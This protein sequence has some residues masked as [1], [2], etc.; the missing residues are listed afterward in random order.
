MPYSFAIKA[1]PTDLDM[2]IQQ[3]LDNLTKPPGS[4]GQLET[5]AA[6]IARIQHTL[7]PRLSTLQHWVFAADHGV[8]AQG[9]SPYPRSVTRQM[10]QNFLA[11]GAAINQFCNQHQ[12]PL[13]IV[14]AGLAG[15]PL[16][17][18]PNLV[19]ARVANGSAD[20]TTQPAMTPTQFEQA[21]TTGADCA[22]Q[23]LAS[24][25]DVL[26]FGEMGIGNTTAAAALMAASLHRHPADC[27]GA[28]TGAST[29]MQHHKIQ[30]ITSAL[31]KHPSQLT[32]GAA[33]M[34]HLGGLELAMMASAMAATA[35]AGHAFIVDGFLAT[36]SL[37]T[38]W[39]DQPAILD[40]ALFSHCS[41]ESGHRA[42]LDAL[43]AKPLLQLDLRLGEGTGAVLA[44]PLIQSAL[45]MLNNMASFDSAGVSRSDAQ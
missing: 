5:L 33:I 6:Q 7:H 22:R 9:V 20:F 25:A 8:C 14:D 34:Q 18:H 37:A 32:D 3:R 30:V 15:E 42:L 36:A 4:L 11:G 21:I 1:L 28:G 41:D 38:L 23:S 17:D 39:K 16:A 10:V 43:N 31:A 24:G 40:Y 26:S 35:E 12:V 2:S 45:A 29:Q 13:K 44:W 27:V 19:Q